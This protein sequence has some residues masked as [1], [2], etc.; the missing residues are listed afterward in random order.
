LQCGL[1]RGYLCGFLLVPEAPLGT[2]VGQVGAAQQE[3]QVIAAEVDAVL[4][5]QPGGELSGSPGS[6]RG[7]DLVTERRQQGR[8]QLRGLAWMRLI[9]ESLEAPLVEE[10]GEPVADGGFAKLEMASDLGDA[11][12]GIRQP[13]HLQTISRSRHHPWRVCA[14]LQLA[15]LLVR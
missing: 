15:P 10:A 13:D 8:S 7:F 9:G 14:L 2:F 4:L 5:G 6:V 12:T 1:L 3:A 11:E